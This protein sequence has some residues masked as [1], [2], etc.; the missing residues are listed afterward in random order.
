MKAMLA[1]VSK[2]E[3]LKRRRIEEKM[4]RDETKSTLRDQKMGG[5]V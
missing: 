3:D 5:E 1:V 4:K 2:Q